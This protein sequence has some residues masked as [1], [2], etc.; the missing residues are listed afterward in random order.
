MRPLKILLFLA[1]L[2]AAPRLWDAV[3]GEKDG[4]ALVEL[5]ALE[6]TY[7]G[8]WT[9]YGIDD[10]DNV[11][12]KMAWTDTM[13]A[14][15]AEIKG[16]RAQVSTTDEMTFEGGKAPPFKVEGKEGYFLQKDGSLGEYFVE[17][18]GQ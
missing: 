16:G 15:G 12:K 13:K 1:V 9:M 11:V 5:S 8:S 3:A 2:L 4:K 14:F 17:T 18:Y 6:G 10:N 7:K